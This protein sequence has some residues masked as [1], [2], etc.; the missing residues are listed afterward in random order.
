MAGGALTARRPNLVDI[1]V[2]ARLRIRR[3]LL[4]MSQEHLANALGITFQQIQ[5]YERGANR[6][7]ASKLFEAAETLSVP[8]AHFF[9]GLEGATAPNT[10]DAGSEAH[11]FL[12]LS[13]G[14]ELA[15]L[16]PLIPRGSLRREVLKLVRTLAEPGD[17]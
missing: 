11:A 14:L 12:G 6:I 13:E 17:D 3:K 10:D 16:F 9:E 2:G 15:R 1:H 4:R 5:K 7:S 8:V